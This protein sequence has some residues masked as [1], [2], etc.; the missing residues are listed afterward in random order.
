MSL[1]SLDNPAFYSQPCTRCLRCGGTRLSVES[2]CP[3]YDSPDADELLRMAEFDFWSCRD[4]VSYVPVGIGSQNEVTSEIQW[5]QTYPDAESEGTVE[6]FQ[7]DL[8][9]PHYE[10][11]ERA[12]QAEIILL[13]DSLP[14]VNEVTQSILQ[15]PLRVESR[16]AAFALMWL[17]LADRFGSKKA[18]TVT[19]LFD[20]EVKQGAE[21][22]AALR[23]SP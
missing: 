20:D 22:L 5:L 21:L 11:R 6:V 10:V 14:S 17:Y 1:F 19:V 9:P 8:A 4:C 12:G 3:H 16:L 23:A 18:M 2:R 15:P 7:I 13:D